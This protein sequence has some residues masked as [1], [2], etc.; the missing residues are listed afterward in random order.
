MGSYVLPHRRSNASSSQSNSDQ[1]SDP[2]D[3]KRREESNHNKYKINSLQYQCRIGSYT[4][5]Y[6]WREIVP[7]SGGSTESD[8]RRKSA[9]LEFQP[10]LLVT[11]EMFDAL[12]AVASGETNHNYPWFRELRQGDGFRKGNQHTGHFTHDST[13][14][15][16]PDVMNHILKKFENKMIQFGDK[17]YC[18]KPACADRFTKRDLVSRAFSTSH[19][20]GKKAHTINLTTKY[21]FVHCDGDQ[22][23]REVYW[24]LHNK[25]NKDRTAPQQYLCRRIEMNDHVQV[26]RPND[27]DVASNSDEFIEQWVKHHK[28]W[29]QTLFEQPL[30]VINQS[31]NQSANH[32]SLLE[33]LDKHPEDELKYKQYTK[34]QRGGYVDNSRSSN[35]PTWRS[36]VV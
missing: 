24:G 28:L 22:V 8:N 9:F 13:R 15:R 16:L 1:Q 27:V 11:Q 14:P 25:N 12:A 26:G 30:P 36:N 5:E 23:K 19:V 6:D 21:E 31:S 7:R 33:P 4:M 2:E 20:L 3:D 34:M 18:L 29:Y 35:A 32:I 17:Q 10:T